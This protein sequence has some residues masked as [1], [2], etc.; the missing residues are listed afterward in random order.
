MQ[1]HLFYGYKDLFR[2]YEPI[3]RMQEDHFSI[4]LGVV[5]MGDGLE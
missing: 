5:R 4:Y 1:E 2:I 3:F